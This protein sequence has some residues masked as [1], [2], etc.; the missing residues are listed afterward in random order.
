MTDQ[1]AAA[2]C[3]DLPGGE[4]NGEARLSGSSKAGGHHALN[5]AIEVRILAPELT[6][7]TAQKI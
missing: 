6:G 5:V 1:L 2:C 3:V 7:R 4:M